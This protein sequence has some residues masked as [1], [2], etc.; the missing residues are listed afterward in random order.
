MQKNVTSIILGIFVFLG[1]S[2]RLYSQL[3]PTVE[4]IFKPP[5]SQTRNQPAN[6][7]RSFFSPHYEERSE[8]IR[9]LVIHS[10]ALPVSEMVKRLN[11]LGASTHYLIDTK[12]N[13]FKMIPENKVAFHA[14][15]SFW[16]GK[17]SLNKS[18]IGIEL[19]NQT[20]GQTPFSK[21]QINAFILLA[22]DIIYRHHIDAKNI[23]AHSDI[24]PTRKVDV[25]K[26]FPWQDIAKHGI[27]LY[28]AAKDT[29]TTETN[30]KALLETI[31]YDTTDTD[32]ALLAFERRFMPELVK[33]DNNINRLEENLKSTEPIIND[34]VIKR[35]NEVADS[36]K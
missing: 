12:G 36:Y 8:P 3:N 16:R 6:Q 20:L 17:N 23:V 35:L 21:K 2:I 14:G 31:G 27:R 15:P 13:V 1:L 34:A 24:A 10:F 30:I 18:A 5:V 4:A 32:K 7:T 22:K 28:P 11:D 19:Q 26:S 9:H 25:G 33:I 29:P